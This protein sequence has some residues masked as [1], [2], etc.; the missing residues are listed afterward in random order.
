VRDQLC[1]DQLCAINCARSIV[2]DQR[3]AI[4]CARSIVRDQPS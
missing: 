2:R 1:G 3:C 4:N